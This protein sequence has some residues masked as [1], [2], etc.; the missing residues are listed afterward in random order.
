MVAREAGKNPSDFKKSRFGH[1]IAEIQEYVASRKAEAASLE[2]IAQVPSAERRPKR[3][4]E[5]KYRDMKSQR[6]LALSMLV[7]ADTL[8]LELSQ[9]LESI[10]AARG[11]L[12]SNVTPIV[13]GRKEEK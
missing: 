4:L 3:S 2:P 11:S 12:Q 10:K 6:D 7:E 5:E 13:S 8:I 1:L 9:E